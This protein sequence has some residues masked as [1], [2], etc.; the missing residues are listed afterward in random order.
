MH[1]TML[2]ALL[3]LAAP[4]VPTALAIDLQTLANQYNVTAASFAFPMPDST[5]DSSAS[6]NYIKKTWDLNGGIDWGSSDMY[7]G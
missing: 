7:V 2:P 1:A 6:A 3:V 5:E 4:L